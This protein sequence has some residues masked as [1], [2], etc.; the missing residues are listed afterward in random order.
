MQPLTTSPQLLRPHFLHLRLVPA[1]IFLCFLLFLAPDFIKNNIFACEVQAFGHCTYHLQ[2]IGIRIT[3]NILSRALRTDY[4]HRTYHFMPDI[5]T[6][7]GTLTAPLHLLP[8]A[9]QEEDANLGLWIG[10]NTYFGLWGE[11]TRIPQI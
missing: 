5:P 3:S 11:R 8:N 10:A 9:L 1:P 2:K 6:Y 7:V 4:T